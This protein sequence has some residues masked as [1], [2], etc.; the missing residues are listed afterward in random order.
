MNSRFDDLRR[1]APRPIFIFLLCFVLMLAAGTANAQE[2]P[3]TAAD[4]AVLGID[5]PTV[6][7]VWSWGFGVILFFWSI[8]FAAGAAIRAI[9]MA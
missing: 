4:L 6:L 1:T 9:R 3:F 2:A 7:Y 5:A 8:G